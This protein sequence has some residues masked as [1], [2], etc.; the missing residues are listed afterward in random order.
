MALPTY[1]GS[2]AGLQL[3][4]QS[5]LPRFVTPDRLV[6]DIEP[7]AA[8]NDAVVAMTR[9]KRLDRILDLHCQIPKRSTAS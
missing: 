3:E 7:A 6:D 4:P 1:L 8:A 2:S 9:P 5:A